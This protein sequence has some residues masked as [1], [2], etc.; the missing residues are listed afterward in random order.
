MG[1]RRQECNA[2]ARLRVIGGAAR[3]LSELPAD[4]IETEEDAVI[5]ADASW[6][7]KIVQTPRTTFC[8]SCAP[9]RKQSMFSLSPETRDKL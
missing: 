8:R 1:R 7:I 5:L 3:V 9:S 2:G 6:V 4:L